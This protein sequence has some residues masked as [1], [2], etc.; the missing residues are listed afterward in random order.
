MRTTLLVAAALAGIPLAA[1]AQS[2]YSNM[3][4]DLAA[5]CA[6][7]HGTNG[8][9]AGGMP[10][11]A[12]QPKD[13]LAMQLRDFRDGKR[14]ATIMH[15]IAKGLSEEQIETVSAYYSAQKPK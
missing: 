8:T 10:N 9:N 3:G 1:S 11:L 2:T 4:R 7:C 14:P 15:Q 5:S 6:I 13:Y 12:G